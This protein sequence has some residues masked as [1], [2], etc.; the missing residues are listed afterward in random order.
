MQAK[1]SDI[2]TWRKQLLYISINADNVTKQKWFNSSPH[3]A[4][5]MHQW[6]VSALVQIMACRQAIIWTNAW[7]LSIGPLVKIFSEIHKNASENIV[8]K[9]AA[10][11]S[12]R[13]DYSDILGGST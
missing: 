12:K 6:I 5:Y 8:Y 11:L 3:G 9:M 10:I 13:W 2:D 7:L 1:L 4:A